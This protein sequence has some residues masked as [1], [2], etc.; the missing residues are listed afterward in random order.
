VVIGDKVGQ[1]CFRSR[2][3]KFF[4]PRAVL[5]KNFGTSGNTF[6]VPRP[7][8]NIFKMKHKLIVLKNL[9]H[10]PDKRPRRAGLGPQ[11]VLCPSLLL[12]D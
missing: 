8:N 2:V 3:G 12:D 5:N 6:K 9:L 10:G 11:A 1:P 4:G 7:G